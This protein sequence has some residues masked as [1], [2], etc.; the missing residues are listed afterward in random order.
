MGSIL[1]LV[2]VKIVITLYV[3]LAFKIAKIVY[4]NVIQIVKLAIFKA[5][6]WVVVMEN[7]WVGENVCYVIILNVLPV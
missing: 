3:E 6:V 5:N 4:K 7:I 2:G 1:V